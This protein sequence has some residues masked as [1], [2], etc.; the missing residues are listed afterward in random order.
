VTAS[1]LNRDTLSITLAGVSV[2]NLL[3]RFANRASATL[4][5]PNAGT[6]TRIAQSAADALTL[7]TPASNVIATGLLFMTWFLGDVSGQQPPRGDLERQATAFYEGVTQ[8]L[9]NVNQLAERGTK[10]EILTR[11]R[12]PL[13]SEY[14]IVWSAIREVTIYE[15][16][17]LQRGWLV[18]F[19]ASYLFDSGIVVQ[20][21]HVYFEHG[22]RQKLFSSLMERYTTAAVE[23]LASMRNVTPATLRH[24]NMCG[25]VLRKADDANWSRRLFAEENAGYWRSV[26]QAKNPVIFA[27][28]LQLAKNFETGLPLTQAIARALK[29][30]WVS[31]QLIGLETAESVKPPGVKKIVEEYAKAKRTGIPKEVAKQLNEKARE[32]LQALSDQK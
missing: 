12:E 26:L 24:A 23:E 18:N 20:A 6:Y 16:N 28:A 32:V 19:S 4:A 17:S 2:A 29:S 15:P 11:L 8:E 3:Y 30:E 10:E 31:L 27:S 1:G 21:P 22:V 13:R 9:A 14:E 5:N 25:L 7:L